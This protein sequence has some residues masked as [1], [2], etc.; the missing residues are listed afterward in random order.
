[1]TLDRII[2]KAA[3]VLGAAVFAIALSACD[4][5][6]DSGFAG[7]Y[8][9]QDTQGN[10]MEI[11]LMEDGSASGKRGDESLTGSWKDD[12]GAA[13]ITWSEEWQTKLAK[14]GDKY[15]KTAYKDGSADGGSVPAEKVE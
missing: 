12:G 9:T 10:P 11:T 6:P 1:M 14:D 7:K 3:A 8:K 13:M 2:H 15:S 4:G 5:A